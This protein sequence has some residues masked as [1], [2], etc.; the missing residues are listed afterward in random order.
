MVEK[1][2]DLTNELEKKIESSGFKLTSISDFHCELE[3][4]SA[5][6]AIKYESPCIIL[7]N[8]D[9]KISEWMFN[10]D[11]PN[12]DIDLIL[13]D[14][15]SYIIGRKQ[16]KIKSEKKCEVQSDKVSFESMLS[17]VLQFFPEERDQYSKN[18]SDLSKMS[19]KIN[20]IKEKLIPQINNMVNRS[21]DDKRLVRLFSGLSKDY[22]FGDDDTRCIIS[23]LFFNGIEGKESRLK[24]KDMLPMYMKKTW[25]ASERYKK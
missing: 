7:E 16:R 19:E 18:F 17:K 9:K 10:S 3:N 2:K 25:I 5:K 15:C 14:F 8:S 4:E 21:R 23:M 13:D 6:Y 1:F 20:F 24:V 22:A 11:T 12:K